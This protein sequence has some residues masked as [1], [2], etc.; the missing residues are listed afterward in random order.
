MSTPN[1]LIIAAYGL[2][3]QNRPG[4]IAN[5]VSELLDVV[6]RAARGCW[7][8]G[9]RINPDFF[10]TSVAV[11]YAAPGWARPANAELVWRLEDV[12]EREVIVVPRGDRTADLARPAVWYL[13]QVYRSAGNPL[14]PVAGQAL[15]IF[16]SQVFPKPGTIDANLSPLWPVQFDELLVREIGLYLAVKDKRADE[17]PA[18]QVE[19]DRWAQLFAAFLE[20]ETTPRVYR[21]GAVRTFNVPALIAAHLA[22][23]AE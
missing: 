14:D 15:T 12:A 1:D 21:Y 16:Y 9:A 6:T 17:V 7:A 2:S 5:K 11:P 8:F 4:D 18:L 20:H 13:G 19:R 3:A 23:G 22:S 10:G